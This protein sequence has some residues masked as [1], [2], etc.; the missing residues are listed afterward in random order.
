MV[1]KARLVE[2]KGY[3]SRRRDADLASTPRAELEFDFNPETLKVSVANNNKGGS[4]PGG[5]S[6]RQYVGTGTTSLSVECVLD[7]T[8][9]GIDVRRKT[10]QLAKFVAAKEIPNDPKQL[11]MPPSC[12]FEWGSFIFEGIVDSLDETL[13]YFSEEGTPLRA[14]VSLKL[15]RDDIVFLPD[16]PSPPGAAAPAA[17]TAGQAPRA[18]A[19]DGDT[20][21]SVA[22]RNGRAD[23]WKAIASANGIDDPLRLR[24]GT[25]LDVRAGAFVSASARA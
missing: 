13:E 19:R 21:R 25:L 6:G 12:R 22:A 3:A 23:D 11:R 9:T 4:Q 24:A 16:A 15:S 18:A 8:E 10:S 17:G 2:I 14:T 20:A 7:S 1:A 5:G